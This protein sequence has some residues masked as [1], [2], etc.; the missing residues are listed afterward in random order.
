MVKS[1]TM[2][3]GIVKKELKDGRVV[4]KA[5]AYNGYDAAGKKI[6]IYKQF[7]TLSE[8]IIW[9][10]TMSLNSNAKQIIAYGRLPL[11]QAF[12]I[13]YKTFKAGH[14]SGA[15]KESYRAN[16]NR[17]KRSAPK[18]QIDKTT[19]TFI[20]TMFTAWANDGFS[21]ASQRKIIHRLHRFFEDMVT[22]NV[23][24]RNPEVNISIAEPQNKK[25]ANLFLDDKVYEKLIRHLEEKQ[26]H[27]EIRSA[28]YIAWVL[29]ALQTGARPGEITALAWPDLSIDGDN[30][31]ISIRHSYSDSG[32]GIKVPKTP[33]SI[34]TIAVPK[35]LADSLKKW[36]AY[37]RKLQMASGARS[38][39]VI[40][41]LDGKF[42]NNI[43]INR[44]L[45]RMLREIC[46]PKEE[47]ITAHK[48]RHTWAT[49]QMDHGVS[50][51]FI[52]KHL[53]HASIRITEETYLHTT[54][55]EF[56]EQAELATGMLDAL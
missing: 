18:L 49:Y 26:Q 47:R 16:I 17:L 21:V 2:P 6:R 54:K 1:Q 37:T 56:N 39:Y 24:N 11:W 4:F 44:W 9:R 29:V 51:A 10:Q 43:L 25:T 7:E 35:R 5:T 48:L 15:T 45:N 38:D 13:H 14:L 27:S 30:P 34:C 55:T 12:E 3:A 52:S 19:R 32:D 31:E 50:I 23:V 22:E 40:M 36:R 20:Q 8:A 53:G 28:L 41:R 33:S 42:P 46:V